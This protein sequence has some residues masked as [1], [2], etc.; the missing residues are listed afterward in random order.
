MILNFVNTITKRKN[1]V[2][3]LFYKEKGF[4]VSLLCGIVAVAAFGAICF[5]LM[6]NDEGE[7]DVS[8]QI[9]EESTLPAAQTEKPKTEEVSTSKAKSE[10]KKKNKKTKKTVQT[11]AE[12]IS[13]TLHFDQ[14]AGLL[15]P[16]NGDILMEYSADSVVYFKTLAQYRTNPAVLIA[17][18]EDDDVKASADGVVLDIETSEET[19]R[20]LTMSIGDNFTVSYGQLKEIVVEKGEHVSEGQVIGKVAAPTKYYTVEGT[21]LYYQVKENDTPVNP[22]VLLR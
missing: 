11:D 17:A 1:E 6:G 12:A 4:Y 14:E 16:V 19:G 8:E 15:W 10:V 3:A 9:V 20:T 7:G 5:N 21:N 18:N 13:N 22:L 2:I